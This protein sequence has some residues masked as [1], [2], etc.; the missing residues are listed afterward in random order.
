MK[1]VTQLTDWPSPLHRASINSFGYGGANAHAILESVDSFLPGYNDTKRVLLPDDQMK[2]YILPFSGSTTQSLESRVTGLAQR[3]NEGHHYDFGNLCHTLSER[4]TKLNKKGFLLASPPTAK[5]DFVVENLVTPKKTFPRLEFGFIFT[6][7]GAQW[8]QMGKELVERYTAFSNTIEYLDSILKKLPE[9]P[10]WS[11]KDAL[12]ETAATSKIGDAT[13]SQPLCTAVQIGIVKLLRLWGVEPS[14]V[15]GHS[16]G[17]IA[18]AYAAGLVSEAHAIIIAFYRGLVMGKITSKGCMLAVGMGPED[19]KALLD[20]NPLKNE[21]TIACVNSPESVTISGTVKAT[22]G[23]AVELQGSGVFNR[24]LATGGRAYHS[25]LMA[26]VGAEYESLVTEAIT[27]VPMPTSRPDDTSSVKFFSSV[28]RDT[29]ALPLFSRETYH[30]I[31]PSYWRANLENPVQFSTAIKNIVSTGKYH[32][33][34]IGPHSALQLP[35]KQIRTFLA[36]P[37]EDLPYTPTL[38][39]GKDADVCMKSL[40]GQLFLSGNDVDFLAVN[41]TDLDGRKDIVAVVHDLPPYQWSYSQLLWNEPRS[42]NELRNRKYVRHELL[43]S[44]VPAS[45]GIERCWRNIIRPAEAPW[46]L[47]H[48]VS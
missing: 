30:S 7:Q 3:I 43:G 14:V 40:A 45:N 31:R 6:G 18:A 44:E 4:R 39:R 46:I 42:S 24:K 28:G 23:L 38:I 2:L 15:A 29:D 27:S 36:L 32:L 5:N 37:E 16:S 22:D 34:E 13:F 10:R 17:E 26:E 41:S 1:I 47:D 19:A 35:I 20:R 25:F 12:L 8:P 9:A 21:L 48:K 33:L 11:I